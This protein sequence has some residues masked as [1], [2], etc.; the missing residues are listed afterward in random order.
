[1][2]FEVDFVLT[3]W[4]MPAM[5]GV[6]FVRELRKHP[7]GRR[8]PVIVVS[9]EGEEDKIATA[10]EAGAN[11]YVTKPFKKELLARKIQS[12][13]SVAALP[14]KGSTETVAALSGDLSSLGFAEL[15]Q[16]LNFSRKT[17]ELFV[18]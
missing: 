17:G 4:N 9:S 7:Q 2:K 15:V 16:F 10:F 6:T 1:L 13:K 14:E 18:K 5:D 8:L 3:D 12:V 11:S